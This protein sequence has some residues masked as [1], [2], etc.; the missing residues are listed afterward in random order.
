MPSSTPPPLFENSGRSSVGERI[1]GVSGA[2]CLSTSRR[3]MNSPGWLGWALRRRLCFVFS[4]CLSGRKARLVLCLQALAGVCLPLEKG[5]PHKMHYELRLANNAPPWPLKWFQVQ[6]MV[7]LQVELR[8]KVKSKSLHLEFSSAPLSPSSSSHSS[9]RTLPGPPP[10]QPQSN[11]DRLQLSS[12][13]APAG[14]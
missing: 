6:L 11:S 7:Q 9:L 12:T 2:R 4:A 8:S 10:T 13:P 3:K 1:L 14:L 5:D